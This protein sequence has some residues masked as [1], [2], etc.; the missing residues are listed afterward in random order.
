MNL[1]RNSVA[2]VYL[3]QVTPSVWLILWDLIWE[4]AESL[5][6]S[7]FPRVAFAFPK[8]MLQLGK[9]RCVQK[10]AEWRGAAWA[11]VHPEVGETWL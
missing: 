1:G 11:V 4:T 8:S 10:R 5:S 3:E 9:W 7:V 2:D 6:H